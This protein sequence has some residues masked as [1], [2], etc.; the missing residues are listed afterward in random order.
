MKK[1]SR[2]VLAV[3]RNRPAP[4]MGEWREKM[5]GRTA[6][7]GTTYSSLR[8][9]VESLCFVRSAYPICWEVL[10]DR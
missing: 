8:N 2:P 1:I 9:W 7:Q 4:T 5:T 6:I 3:E 10:N